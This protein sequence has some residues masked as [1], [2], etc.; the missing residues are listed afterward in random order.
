MDSGLEVKGDIMDENR[1]DLATAVWVLIMAFGIGLL[2]GMWVGK[3]NAEEPEMD[4]Y[5][6]S[7]D[8]KQETWNEYPVMEVTLSRVLHKGYGGPEVF[9]SKIRISQI[10]YLIPKQEGNIL[11]DFFKRSKY[12]DMPNNV[13]SFFEKPLT[14]D[15]KLVEKD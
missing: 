15:S 14:K 4:V 8:F 9:K 6:V 5:R 3:A 7:L 1:K 12:L 13:G 11:I 2:L 10:D